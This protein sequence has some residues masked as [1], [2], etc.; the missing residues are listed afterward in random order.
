MDGGLVGGSAL[1]QRPLGGLEAGGPL[2]GLG[3]QLLQHVE[4]I[5]GHL[6]VLQPH[7]QPDTLQLG[8]RGGAHLGG[9]QQLVERRLGYVCAASLIHRR[10]HRGLGGQRQGLS[11]TAQQGRQ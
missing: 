4:L 8:R 7:E 6:H 5:G 3:A 10:G 11:V 2:H 9:V 1:Q